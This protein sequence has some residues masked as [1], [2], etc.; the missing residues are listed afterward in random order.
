MTINRHNCVVRVSVFSALLVWALSV[1]AREYD[2]TVVI[3]FVSEWRYYEAGESP[4]GNWTAL[5]YDD[6]GWLSGTSP[7]GFREDR[8]AYSARYLPGLGR[9]AESWNVEAGTYAFRQVFRLDN[10]S[11]H[12]QLRIDLVVTAGAVVYVNG[13]QVAVNRRMPEA[14]DG[15]WGSFA[16]SAVQ[17]RIE[18]EHEFALVG[19][20][21]LREGDNVI[22]VSTHR[23]A[24]NDPGLYFMA[25]LVLEDRRAPW[26]VMLSWQSDPATTMTI[27]WHLREGERDS[28]GRLQYRRRGDREWV[29][30]DSVATHSF[31]FSERTFERAELTGLMPTAEYEFRRGDSLVYWFRTM[32]EE[33]I[34][35]LVFAA[36]G[37]TMHRVEWM[38]QM[39]REVMNHDPDFVVWGGDFAYADGLAYNAW[40]WHLWFAA[41]MQTLVAKDGRVVPIIGA[42]GNHEVQR[43]YHMD[44]MKDNFH[45][46]HLAPFF[47]ELFAFPGLP[48]YA[49]LDF[50]DYLSLIILD[51]D[52]ANPLVGEQLEW[53]RDALQSRLG[54]KHVIP[55]YHVPAFPST[56]DF[57]TASGGVS[58]AIREHWLP[59]FEQANVRSALEHHDHAYKRTH[60]I[61][62]GRIDPSGIVY[63]GDGAWGVTTRNIYDSDAWYLAQAIGSA[64]SAGIGWHALIITLTPESQNY[65]VVNPQGEVMDAFDIA[66]ESEVRRLDFPSEAIAFGTFERTWPPLPKDIL[67]SLPGEIEF[68]GNRYVG[69]V[70]SIDNGRIDLESVLRPPEGDWNRAAYVFIPLE[71]DEDRLVTLGMGADWNLTAWLDGEL[72]IDTEET[73]NQS[74]PPSMHD[75][76][77][78]VLLKRGT[79][80]LAIRLIP[81]NVG[82]DLVVGG[83]TGNLSVSEE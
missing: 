61:R 83:W 39:N 13:E 23:A 81:G 35:T 33:L 70:V 43:S 68:R 52:H 76:K 49:T 14:G 21:L 37:D 2:P 63:V 22:A 58:K 17:E 34:E 6:S 75:F 64:G 66:V 12:D 31:P 46:R 36:G 3:P 65:T 24:A 19:S 55:V 48:G 53:L 15:S 20:E 79:S 69:V 57:E 18:V 42:I 45:R 80:V 16:E 44:R 11:Q 38:E 77:A 51:S 5:D 27:D 1:V 72:L 30:A 41:N 54:V 60:P 10:V 59:L 26:G 50:G 62:D 29:T 40:R 9:V 56:K 8:G 25:R 4:G 32:P 78:E 7:L 28:P 67:A 74:W 71:S 47:F 73:G 82:A